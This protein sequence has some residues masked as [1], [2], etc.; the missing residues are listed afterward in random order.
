MLHL[1]VGCI[2][3]RLCCVKVL[4]AVRSSLTLSRDDVTLRQAAETAESFVGP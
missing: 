2:V 4:R 1:Q 3:L